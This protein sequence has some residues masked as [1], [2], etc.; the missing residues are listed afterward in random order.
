[1]EIYKT[2]MEEIEETKHEEEVFNSLIII[3]R[4][5]FFYRNWDQNSLLNISKKLTFTIKLSDDI[6][7]V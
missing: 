7:F 1:M 5:F 3:D 4:I 2:K 6:L